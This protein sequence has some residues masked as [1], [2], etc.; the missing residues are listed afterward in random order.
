M[1]ATTTTTRSA[2]RRLQQQLQQQL[3]LAPRRRALATNAT[4]STKAPSAAV[5]YSLDGGAQ[6]PAHY[7]LLDRVS[8]V[9][10]DS[11]GAVW[12]H[13]PQR[14]S[15]LEHRRLNKSEW[16]NMDRTKFR[17]LLEDCMATGSVSAMLRRYLDE[18][19]IMDN[20]WADQELVLI[21]GALIKANRSRIAM[22]VL[23][24]QISDGAKLS[25]LN[26]VAAE[27]ARLGNA[28]VALGLLDIASH[29]NLQPDVVTYTSAIHACARG[30]RDNIPQTFEILDEMLRAGVEPNHRTYGAV[31][32]AYARLNRWED[33][34]ALMESIPFDQ[35]LT[36]SD[37]FTS[38]IITCSRNFQFVCAT[39][40]YAMLMKDG[41]YVGENVSNAALSA[42]AR[43]SDLDT[44]HEIVAFLERHATPS[45]FTYN[46][47]IS[48]FGNA[49]RVDDAL[50][51]FARMQQ[52]GAIEPDRVTYNA[53][54]MAARRSR[55]PDVVP[56]ILDRMAQ[57]GIHWDAYT[58]NSLLELC[59]LSG[60]VQ[61]AQLYW[62]QAKR[63]HGDGARSG[64]GRGRGMDRAN[65][66]TLLGVYFDAGQYDKVLSIWRG[67]V[68]CRRRAK[69]AKTLNYLLR[70]CAQLSQVASAKELIAEFE[71]RGQKISAI[72]Q[73]HLLT[74]CL[75]A[76]DDLAAQSQLRVM[77]SVPTWS[78][79]FAFTAVM[80]HAW[81]KEQHADVLDVFDWYQDTLRQ[82]QFAYSPQLH[83]PA[84]AIYI[85]AARAAARLGD[86]ERL[87]SIYRALRTVKPDTSDDGE[88]CRQ[89]KRENDDDEEEEEEDDE[90]EDDEQPRAM[91]PNGATP[92]AASATLP[93]S[94][95]VTVRVEIA[96][97][98]LA[99]CDKQLDWRCAVSMYDELS[100][101]VDEDTNLALY[102]MVVKTVG[103]AGEFESALD[104]N[105]GEWYRKNRPDQG[106]F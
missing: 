101:L 53:L 50:E 21:V 46:T 8:T 83:F 98:L 9:A 47:I 61:R 95:S 38:A 60:D 48:A 62:E 92:A 58:L 31:V 25:R 79:V 39:R 99:S 103:R 66:E 28:F 4:A 71:A 29:F 41:V 40:L 18:F 5:G 45:I 87:V 77:T 22:D 54:L 94:T 89:A 3:Q 85:L 13:R 14:Y 49:R 105:G 19:P 24:N 67:N 88:D 6:E 55:R 81:K 70:S 56:G 30:A 33:I 59:Q 44:M 90:A 11:S 74:T 96:R 15:P 35:Q 52:A 106:W 32:L 20:H 80:K 26:R 100:T 37:V 65:Y 73:N 43:T 102:E 97:L 78:T 86:H 51:V 64:V 104:V 76:D 12:R 10:E 75:M 7:N 84:D 1:A 91:P 69:S 23:R 42:C 72:A 16:K 82:Y 36:K 68:T 34:E 63:Q 93:L 57:Q 27:S 2:L 17:L